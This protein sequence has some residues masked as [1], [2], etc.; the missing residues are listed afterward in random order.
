MSGEYNYDDQGQFFPFFMLTMAGLVTIPLTYNVLKA[1][2]DLE[3]TAARIKSDFKPKHGDLIEAQRKK[4]KR[5][6]RKTKRII[7]VIL[8]Y[9]FM[10]YMVY[11][12]V[13]TQRT[14]PQI[15]DPYDILGVKRSATEQEINKFYKRQSVK[16]HPDKARPDPAKNETLE[17]INDRW[18]E[19]TKAYKALTDEEI[20]NN[21]LQYGNPDG[22]QSTSIGI[23]LPKWMVE[24]GNRWFV[25]AFYGILLGIILP[26][27][28]GKWWYGTQALT[29]DKVL[30]ASAGN[31][32]REWKEDISEGGVVAATSVGEEFKETLKEARS[33][34]GAAKVEGK[35]LNSSALTEADKA[36]LK[37]IDDPVRRKTLAL[38]WAYLARIELE[39]T[40]LE[41][42]KYEVAPTALLLNN[43]FASVTLPFQ[44]VKPLLAAYHTSQNIIQAVPPSAS[45]LLQL[46]NFTPEIA[47]KITASAKSPST[48]PIF[49]SLPPTVRRSLCSD[50][51]DEQYNQAMQVAS[52]IPHLQIAKAFFKV[53][54]ERVITP[55]SLVQLVIKARVIPP[56][57]K[58]VPPVDP[59]DLEDIDPDEGDLDAL[60]GRKPA[61]SKRRKTLDGKVIEDESKDGSIQPPLAHAPYFAADHAPR[62]HV[63]LA[64]ARSG[65]IS[66]P[67][68]T[69]TAFDK[70]IFNSDGTPSFNV[71]TFKCPFQ[72]PPQIHAFPFVLHLM[73][74]SY[75]GLDWKMDV[76]LDVRDP[77]E[78]NAV[79]S[80]DEISEP[81]E[82]TL[83]GQL[84][85]MKTGGLSGAA[86]TSTRRKK[87][88]R[89][90][91]QADVPVMQTADATADSEDDDDDDDESDTE[92]DDDESD[93][94]DTDTETEDED[95]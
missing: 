83:A 9:A 71:L 86:P 44:V 41:R 35:V 43:S 19:M 68:F 24:E 91:S 87:K 63:F 2:T 67:P 88:K 84:Q 78:A 59:L 51:S 23:A 38:L 66:V 48:L 36:R 25:V 60:H 90:A 46:P 27:T 70:P 32:F 34:A 29:K 18:V 55:G 54:G 13:V 57:T 6:D 45:P 15:W 95:S 10:A 64:E 47:A 61:K 50:L 74:D 80:D 1:S 81:D 72:A 49:M 93:T 26:Y 62:W 22:R 33:D 39:D 20:R 7:A 30:H 4:R 76:V 73:C 94:S 58:A 31:L 92:G 75:I 8:G 17:T 21:Y 77:S 69:F 53:V 16:F 14:V 37:S 28:L 40:E 85:A 42:E 56:G 52:Q 79:E 65:R 5:R 12:I 3:Q 11:L 82:D 89:T